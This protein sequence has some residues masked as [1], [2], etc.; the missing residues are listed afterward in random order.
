M[1]SM[2][3]ASCLGA[4]GFMSIAAGSDSPGTYDY[5]KAPKAEVVENYH[6]IKVADPFRP[7]EDPDSAE[8]KAWVQAEN[9]ITF[10]YLESIPERKAIKDRLTKLWNYEKFSTPRKEGSSYFYSKNSGLQNQSVLYVTVS[11][12]AEPRV[13]L[14]PN[15][16]TADGTVA[17]AGTS[18]SDDGKL[19][20]YGLAAAG[21]DWNEWRVRDVETGKDLGDVLKWIKFSSASWTKDGKGFYYGRFPEP[22]KGADLK[23]PNFYNKLY[24][25]VLGAP[26]DHDKLVYER[27]DQKEWQF[28]GQVSDSGDYLVIT[29][30]KGTDDKYMVLYQ[31]LKKAGSPIV[32]LIGTL[33][34][35]YT[36][37]DNDGPVFWFKSNKALPKARS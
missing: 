10:A 20:A 2:R 23:Q 13:L 4:I 32:E 21:S 27:P 24:Y 17:L 26:Q 34:H 16:L 19:M 37:L 31:D 35:E 33:E 3:L 22:E 11:L 36:F 8:T 12:D 6:G 28:H 5:P 30:S 15:T 9:K 25:H 18:I 1:V 7:L 14:D 29:V